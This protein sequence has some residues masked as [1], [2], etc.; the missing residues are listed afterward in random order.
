MNVARG[1][2]AAIHFAWPAAKIAGAGLL[3]CLASA[4]SPIAA[5]T[6]NI[7]VSNEKSSTLTVLDANDTVVTTIET[8]ARPR[9]MHFSADRRQFYV[10]CA[11]DDQIAIYDTASLE[12]VG[13]ILDVEEP[14]TF[15]LHPDGRRLVIS[16]EEDATATVFDVVE[17]EFLAE[18]ETGE[19]PEG[20]QIT[21][22]GKRAFVASEAANLVHV[23]D[24]EK[25]EV[26]KDILV[27]TRPRRF[28]L[29]PDGKELWVSAELAGIVNIIDLAALKLI[30]DIPFLPTGFRKEQVTPV[31]VLITADGQRAYVALGRANHVAVVDVPKRKVIDYILVGKRSWGLALTTD[32]K[33]LYVANGLS[34]DITIIDTASLKPVKSVPVGMVPY[35]ILIDDH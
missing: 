11:D 18:F 23:I 3:A 25:G 16:N 10:G 5:G 6:G 15:D 34:D 19:E 2:F 24:L 27:D 9:G 14:E 30:A 22:D 12:L 28:A 4:G 8:C 33:K 17:R 7:I 21:P 35:G 32:E 31:D 26:I 1:S 20:V 13:R 29:T